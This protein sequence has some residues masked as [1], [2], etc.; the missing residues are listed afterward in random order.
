MFTFKDAFLSFLSKTKLPLSF[1][2]LTFFYNLLR[3]HSQS[4]FCHSLPSQEDTGI[5]PKEGAS[6]MGQG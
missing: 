6:V 4:H 1:V 2:P 3:L 5:F